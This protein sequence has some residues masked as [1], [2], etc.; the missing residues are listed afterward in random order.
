[1][2]TEAGCCCEALEEFPDSERRTD[3][4]VHSRGTGANKVDVSGTFVQ[5]KLSVV[6]HE[7]AS[8]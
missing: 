1:M 6:D 5:M 7:R 3:D 2:T 8:D 4:G